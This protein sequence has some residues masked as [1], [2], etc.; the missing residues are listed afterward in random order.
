MGEHDRVNVKDIAKR[1]AKISTQTQPTFLEVSPQYSL[2]PYQKRAV[3]AV[4][5]EL[6]DHDR[7]LLHAPTG[8]G[9]TRMAMNVVSMHLRQN[10]PTMVLWLAPTKELVKQAAEDF[11]VAW[12][13]Q[14]DVPAVVIQWR[15]GG[16]TFS[17]GTT[18]RRN[19]VL[20]AGIHMAGKSVNADPW[21]ER[22][23]LEKVSLVVFDEAHHSIAPTFQELVE[24]ILTDSGISSRRLLGLSATPGRANLEETKSLVEMYEGR[25]V[26]IGEGNNPV[27]YLVDNGFLAR[28]V[29]ETHKVDFL[30]PLTTQGSDYAPSDLEHL[31]QNEDH[32]QEIVNLVQ[33]L[34]DE[35][36]LRVIAFT[37]SVDSAEKCA[38]DMH[39][40]GY[41]YAHAVSGVTSADKRDYYTRTFQQPVA[42]NG[43]PQVLFNCN[44]LTAGFDA[45]EISAAVIGQP[46]KSAVRL[47]QMIGRALRGP[48]SGGTEK[49]VIHMLVDKSFTKY[50][51]LADMFCQWESIWEESNPNEPTHDSTS[52]LIEGQDND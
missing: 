52:S 46:T 31:G 26:V 4:L 41:A 9:K 48:Q 49:A 20:V 38:A 8:S 5:R 30:S 34:F 18:I 43:N 40:R 14:G 15:G 24:G 37:P 7:V 6:I 2:R 12:G 1:T 33:E 23:L 28:A 29:V 44:V 32:N 21:I 19:T 45:P 3:D 39:R 27:R 36:H 17:H 51:E 13:T 47:Q 22:S 10:A 11:S 50:A 35:G 16:E 42:S 25:K